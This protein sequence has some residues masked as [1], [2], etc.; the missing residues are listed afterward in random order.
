MPVIT[1][2]I[3]RGAAREHT[4]TARRRRNGV[5]AAV[6]GIGAFTAVSLVNTP[7]HA[8]T[9]TAVAPKAIQT[10]TS[11]AA[12]KSVT[13]VVSG[14]ST[15]VP[16]D[17]T[18][19]QLS[20]A[21]TKEL[22][23]GSLVLSP[24]LNPTGVGATVL[25]A[26][27]TATNATVL[28]GVGSA[29][30]ITILNSSAGSLTVTVKIVGYS[31]DVYA[32][33]IN[34]AGG[35]AGQ[36]LTN[37]G[38]GAAWTSVGSAYGLADNFTT[39]VMSTTEQFY[40]AASLSVPSGSYE[41]SFVSTLRSYG[42]SS[43]ECDLMSPGGT[44]VTRSFGTASTAGVTAFDGIAL[45]GLINTDGGTIAVKCVPHGTSVLLLYP[46]LQAIK[47]GSV[48]SGIAPN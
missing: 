7:A 9:I 23:A 11:I 31:T 35:T 29:N 1:I 16:T 32:S 25:F 33:D 43:T 38:T 15:T 27:N 26:A 41:V 48:V 45:N 20:V 6:I 14:G 39:V 3:E 5:I 12:N 44:P 4:P 17:A 46:T 22:G 30:K 42:F 18:R 8:N 2:K 13:P 24:Y 10:S 21:I 19:V 37:S 36:V 40:P 47:V 34:S 28:V